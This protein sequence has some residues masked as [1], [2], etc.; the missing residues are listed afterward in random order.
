MRACD[1]RAPGVARAAQVRLQLQRDAVP[2][3]GKNK[4]ARDG[5]YPPHSPPPPPP[6]IVSYYIS[7]I[8]LNYPSGFPQVSPPLSYIHIA[9]PKLA[10]RPL[11]ADEQVLAATPLPAL[12][13]SDDIARGAVQLHAHRGLRAG[14]GPQSACS[15]LPF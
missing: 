12:R 9:E 3:W 6:P 5:R 8:S 7:I 2:I 13:G 10:T 1:L 15:L 14:T 11:A 4:V